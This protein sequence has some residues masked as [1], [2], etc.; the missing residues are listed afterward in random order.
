[1]HTLLNNTDSLLFSLFNVAFEFDP[2]LYT[3]CILLW[4]CVV[5]GRLQSSGPIK[6]SKFMSLKVKGE[7]GLPSSTRSQR[8]DAGKNTLNSRYISQYCLRNE[9]ACVQYCY[10]VVYCFIFV[11]GSCICISVFLISTKFL[12]DNCVHFFW[13]ILLCISQYYLH[14]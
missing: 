14:N 3:Y 8:L 6:T 7:K 1:M 13:F 11:F 9:D 12:C 2:Y 5:C 10:F 4:Q